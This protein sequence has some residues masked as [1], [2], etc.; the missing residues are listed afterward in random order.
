MS[1]SQR[2]PDPELRTLA[3]DIS[4]GRV[5][6]SWECASPDE[7]RSSFMVLMLAG[8]E[9][10]PDPTEVAHVYEY[11]SQAGPMAVNGR[12]MFMSARFLHRADAPILQGYLK[13]LHEQRKAWLGASAPEPEPEPDPQHPTPPTA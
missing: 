6:G 3:L 11:M 1:A 8:P 10:L 2:L 5:F 13:S 12:P 9:N 7:V 4:E